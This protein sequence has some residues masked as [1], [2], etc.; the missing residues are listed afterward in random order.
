MTTATDTTRPIAFDPEMARGRRA[1]SEPPGWDLR[2]EQRLSSGTMLANAIA[3]FGMGLGAAELVFPGRIS[4]ALGMEDKSWLLRL[5]GVREIGKSLGIFNSRVPTGWMWGRVAGD[6]LD[7]AT[8]ATALGPRNHKRDRV[9]FAMAAV[10]GVAV[11]DVVCAKQLTSTRRHPL[12]PSND[13]R[14]PL[15]NGSRR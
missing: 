7:L 6:A 5:Y 10:A 13:V 2:T 9:A 11:L 14:P 8:L 12:R 15:G 1:P 4:S 3:W